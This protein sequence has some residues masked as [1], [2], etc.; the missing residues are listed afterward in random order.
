[1]CEVV[2]HVRRCGGSEVVQEDSGRVA[3]VRAI[4][5]GGGKGWNGENKYEGVEKM[6]RDLRTERENSPPHAQ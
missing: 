6:P 4:G 1:M 2:C 5:V 3:C